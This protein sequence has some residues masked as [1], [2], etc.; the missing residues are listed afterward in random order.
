MLDIDYFK[1][2]NDQFGHHFGDRTLQLFGE[3]LTK[4]IRKSDLAFRMGGEEFLVLLPG[5]H[6]QD[7]VAIVE[8]WLNTFRMGVE[9]GGT[10][11]TLTLSAGIATVSGP[12]A[13]A[14]TMKLINDAD[15]AVYRAKNGGRDQ[16]SVFTS[17]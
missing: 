8:R 7:A 6:T 14:M 16:L 5:T 17:A 11:L 13:P 1:K 2:I 4:M 12:D 9:V 15:A 3:V 10:R